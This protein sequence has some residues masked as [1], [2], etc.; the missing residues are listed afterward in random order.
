MWNIHV[1][2]EQNQLKVYINSLYYMGLSAA[3]RLLILPVCSV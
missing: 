2:L 1:Q 3:W